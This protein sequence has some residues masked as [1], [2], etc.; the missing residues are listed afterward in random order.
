MR[1]QFKL[2]AIQS[3]MVSKSVDPPPSPGNDRSTIISELESAIEVALRLADQVEWPL[4]AIKL[5]EA[6]NYVRHGGHL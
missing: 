3:D 2:V 5:D 4:V 6:L 1:N